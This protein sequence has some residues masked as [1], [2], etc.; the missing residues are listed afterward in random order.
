[1]E[2]TVRKQFVPL[3]PVDMTMPKQIYTLQPTELPTSQQVMG[4]EGSCNLWRTY[5]GAG[6]WW[7]SLFLKDCSP[8][9]GPMLEQFLN[10]CS[11]WQVFMLEQGKS[12]RT[13]E[14]QT[15]IVMYWPQPPIPHPPCAAS[16]RGVSI[17][18]EGMKLSLGRRGVGEGVLSFA[19]SRVWN[20]E[21]NSDCVCDTDTPCKRQLNGIPIVPFSPPIYPIFV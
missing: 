14:W 2:K 3:H 21:G 15:G 8:W 13:K 4:P 7:S 20:S 1:M 5:A 19:F 10:N 18:N 16:G 12:T 6:S 11:P 17:R 9:E